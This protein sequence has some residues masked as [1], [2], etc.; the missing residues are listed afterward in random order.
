MFHTQ[1]YPK[2]FCEVRLDGASFYHST[3]SNPHHQNMEVCLGVR[4]VMECVLKCGDSVGGILLYFLRS[5]R[6]E[7]TDELELDVEGDDES[8]S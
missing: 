6:L 7:E 4:K 2:Y 8:V 1:Q 5:W 3:Y